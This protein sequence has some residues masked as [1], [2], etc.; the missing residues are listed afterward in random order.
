VFSFF[1][2]FSDPI[3]NMKYPVPGKGKALGLVPPWEE[4]D[5]TSPHASWRSHANG[6][7]TTL[8]ES[9]LQGIHPRL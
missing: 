9:L 8:V 3:Y 1:N 5:E 4:E 6:A 7:K 2:N